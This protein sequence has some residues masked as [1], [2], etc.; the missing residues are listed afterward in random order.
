MLSTRAALVAWACL[1][2]PAFGAEGGTGGDKHGSLPGTTASSAGHA[3]PVV[4]LPPTFHATVEPTEAR[5]GQ[6]VA[7]TLTVTNRGRAMLYVPNP[8]QGGKALQLRLT[9][10]TG[11][12][13]TI[14]PGEQPG[15]VKSRLVSIGVRPKSRETIRFDLREHAPIGA[16][17][18]Y[19]I[20]LDYEWKANQQ[21]HSP[22]LKL[23]IR[24]G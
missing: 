4:A 23:F 21:W 10:P 22:E 5:A 3:E 19:S 9:F 16:P 8:L 6:P 11:E 2:G 13:R 7:I 17:G 12:V 24:P 18:N 15:G 1:A 20:F 14:N